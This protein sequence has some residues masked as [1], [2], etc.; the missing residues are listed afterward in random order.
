MRRLICTFVVRIWHKTRFRMTWPNP[1]TPGGLFY[2]CSLAL[3]PYEPPHYKTNKMACVPS[4][5]SDQPGHP[6]SLIRVFAVCM[7]K[8]W[9]FNYPLS[10][11][12]RLWSDWAD[13]LDDL[14]SSLGAVILFVL[15]LIMLCMD[16]FIF[17]TLYRNACILCRHRP[18]RSGATICDNQSGPTVF[19]KWDTGHYYFFFFFF[20]IWV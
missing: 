12:Q 6:P 16:Y 4:E 10:A 14:E 18:C 8:A 2:P 11:Q 15:S 3:S 17:I 7:K 5:D 9:A 19:A 1:F 13:A 20:L